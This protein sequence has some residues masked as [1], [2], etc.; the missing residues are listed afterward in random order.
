MPGSPFIPRAD[1]AFRTWAYNF[2]NGI[3]A[4]P[5][6]YMMSPAEGAA[7]M[8]AYNEFDAAFLAATNPATRTRGT[9]AAKDDAHS[10]LE[11]LCRSYAGIIRLN[12][13]ITDGDKLGI[14]VR[15]INTSHRRRNAPQTSPLLKIIGAT[16][17]EHTMRYND[18][19]TPSS[20]AKP[21]GAACLQLFMA[22]TERGEAARIADAKF[23]GSY[24]RNLFAVAHEPADGG[25]TATYWG[26]WAG[27]RG[28]V[29]P[30]SLPVSFT[31]A[32][33]GAE[34]ARASKP[35]TD[36]GDLRLAA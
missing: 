11:S 25:K 36:D 30:W 32:W 34:P 3:N 24:T 13:G 2:C 26:R 17:G 20:A 27:R 12:R 28:D 15:P 1:A 22:V 21:F 6:W 14:G 23:V 33:G 35:A 5:S 10:I 9:V 19:N 8:R 29:G 18:S 16:P 7:L 4:N 31:I